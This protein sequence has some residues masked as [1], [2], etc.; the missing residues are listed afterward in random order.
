VL[1]KEFEEN[2]RG[3]HKI[4]SFLKKKQDIINPDQGRYTWFEKCI[5]HPKMIQKFIYMKDST[6]CLLGNHHSTTLIFFL[7]T[8]IM[9]SVLPRNEG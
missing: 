3:F 2:D 1:F 9:G 6:V 5:P 8:V 4:L 7:L